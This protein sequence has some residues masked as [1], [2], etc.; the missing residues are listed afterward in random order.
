MSR[1]SAA[2]S[3][4]VSRLV[5]IDAIIAMAQNVEGMQAPSNSITRVNALCRGGIVLLSSHLE[6]YIEDLGT[7][8]IERIGKGQVGKAALSDSFRYYLSRDLIIEI[9][10]TTNPAV[11]ASKITSFIQRDL[12]IWDSS[13]HFVH[14]LRPETFVGQFATPN[15][16][17][18]RRFFRRFGYENLNKDLANLLKGDYQI[19]ITMVNNIV[20]QRN[21]IAHGDHL[22][23]GT[24]TD[25]AQMNAWLKRYCRS[26]DKIVGD[27]FKNKG[28]VIRS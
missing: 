3:N 15:H 14:P 21:K 18:I 19:S 5:E 22:A 17:N 25:L 7:L 11:V 20:D 24:P 13:T 1:Y 26:I 12:N 2:Y 6:G 16:R 10:E 8:A 4:L 28:C 27:W 23:A 9:T